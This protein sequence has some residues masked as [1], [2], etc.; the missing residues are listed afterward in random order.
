MIF[1]FPH[2]FIFCTIRTMV[3]ASASAGLN[4][5]A[6]YKQFASTNPALIGDRYQ[7]T[8]GAL[9]CV[10]NGVGRLFWGVLSDTIGFKNS[11]TILTIAQAGL[12]AIFHRLAGSKI[13]FMAAICSVFFLLV[14]YSHR[15]H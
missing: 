10:C 12:H 7:A 15:V 9:A 11:F 1:A 4:V 8:V 13:S 2:D 5:V 3:V 6:V 14:V